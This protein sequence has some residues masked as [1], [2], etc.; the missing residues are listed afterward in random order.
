M[1]AP[2]GIAG[3]QM[4]QAPSSITF[5]RIIVDA[6]PLASYTQITKAA[7][8]QPPTESK[9]A[10]AMH[11]TVKLLSSCLRKIDPTIGGL[12]S[13][14][15]ASTDRLTL[16]GRM[17]PEVDN[18]TYAGAWAIATSRA[19]TETIR[20]IHDMPL[21][22]L[23]EWIVYIDET[24]PKTHAGRAA[25]WMAIRSADDRAPALSA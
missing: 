8:N 10:K 3:A 12:W 4:A 18:T 13:V 24:A 15:T 9:M 11:P 5:L 25:A 21:K 22:S 20:A 2:S 14:T 17:V 1:A 16:A 7:R 19:T 6:L 23:C